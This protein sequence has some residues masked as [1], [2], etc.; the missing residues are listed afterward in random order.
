VYHELSDEHSAIRDMAKTFVDR[1]VTPYA[2]E[3][4]RQEDLDRGIVAQLADA[5]ILGCS[6]PEEYGGMGIDALGYCLIMEELG[7]GCSSVRGIVS[8]NVGLVGKAIVKFG[9]AE[10]KEQWLPPLCSGEGLACFALTE[11]NSGSDPASLTTRARRDGGDYVISGAKMF[12]TNG[13]WASVAMVFARADDDPRNGIT[14]FMVP[15]SL[16]GFGARRIKGKL[17]LRAQDTAELSF[18]EVRIPAS[19][20]IGELGRGMKVALTALD[21]GRMG[22]AASCVGISQACLDVGLSYAKERTQFGKPIAKFQLIQEMLSD[23]A[24]DT[25]A[26]RL[27]TW[28]VAAAAERGVNHSLESSFAKLFATEAA[29]RSSN[30]ALQ[31]HGGYGYIDEYAVGKYMRDARVMTLYEGTSQIQKLLI[32]RI[33]TGESAFL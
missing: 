12:I 10:Q 15:T 32:G 3:W 20:M 11:P 26:A 14:C 30:T 2:A 33:L 29:V 18:D 27:L 13:S 28:N 31:I 17:G 4:D 9:T 24:L 16:P 8:V 5:G 21:A 6:I 1:N 23:I 25:Q 19:N 22:I 7:R